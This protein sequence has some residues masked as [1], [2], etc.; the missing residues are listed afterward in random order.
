MPAATLEAA[1]IK[2]L[3]IL[4]GGGMLPQKLLE[5][6]DQK[7]I[8]PFVVGFEGQ[9]DPMVIQGRSHMWTRLGAA[10]HIIKTLKSHDIKDLV[11]IGSIRHPTIAELR[12]DLKAAEFFAKASWKVIGGDNGIGEALRDFLGKE[13]FRIHG[14]QSI[15]QNLLAPEGVVGSVQPDRQDWEDIEKGIE[16]SQTARRAG[17]RAIGDRASKGSYTGRR[18][19][20]GDRQAYGADENA[21]AQGARG[22]TG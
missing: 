5:A 6:C 11:F 18:R 16:V 9:T 10:G 15:A 1:P 8:T 20:R 13:G 4:A 19:G 3:G 21:D 2:S 14:I 17:Y 12:P 22:N 7:G